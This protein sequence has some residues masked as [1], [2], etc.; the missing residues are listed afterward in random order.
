MQRSSTW[1]VV[2]ALTHSF[3]VLARDMAF[4]LSNLYAPEHLIIND[5]DVYQWVSETLMHP[6]TITKLGQSDI[7][8]QVLPRLV[9]PGKRKRRVDNHKS[10]PFTQVH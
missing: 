6:G 1:F 8:I 2:K 5:E 7:P 3:T 4:S 9:L 10:F